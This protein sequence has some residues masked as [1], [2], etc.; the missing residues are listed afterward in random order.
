MNVSIIRTIIPHNK[1][2]LFLSNVS[3][4]I[5][6]IHGCLYLISEVGSKIP[7]S[8]L[9]FE[10]KNRKKKTTWWYKHFV[11]QLAIVT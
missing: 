9:S 6:G 1:K 2:D 8:N 4:R 3:V 10:K 5:A 7:I 11:F